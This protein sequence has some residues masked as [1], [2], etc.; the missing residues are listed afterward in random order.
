MRTTLFVNVLLPLPVA[1][2][3]T[4]RVPYE[5]NESV[6]VGKRVVVQ[7]GQKKIYTALIRETT[8]SPPPVQPKYILS[9][10]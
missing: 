6:A 1:G 10:L 5:L 7:F 9:V 2:Y 4:Y 3:F 8:E